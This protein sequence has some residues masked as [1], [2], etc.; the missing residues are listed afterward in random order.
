MPSTT[1]IDE[2]T[3]KRRAAPLARTRALALLQAINNWPAFSMKQGLSNQLAR[4]QEA[5]QEY[6]RVTASS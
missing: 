6:E 5:E 1:Q 4:L 2:Q 3:D